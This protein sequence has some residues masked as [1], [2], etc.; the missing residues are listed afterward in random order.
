MTMIWNS[1]AQV[2]SLVG[3]PI[4]EILQARERR[5]ALDG[6]DVIYSD[7]VD[8]IVRCTYRIWDE[9]NVGLIRTHYSQ[10]CPVISLSGKLVGAEAMLEGTVSALAACPDRS[11]VAE[12]VIWC[13]EEPG[14]FFSSHRIMSTSSHLGPDAVLG[15]PIKSGRAPIPVIADCVCRNNRII[16][17]WL[18][19]DYAQFVR[20]S[21]L[22]PR[23]V[24]E[25][26]ARS[27]LEGDQE[28]HRWLQD[29]LERVLGCGTQEPPVDHP[30]HNAARA[31]RLAY[32]Q[33]QYG[34]AANQAAA[35]IEL[36]WPSARHLVGR[37]A[38]IGCLMQL[39]A[40][41]SEHQ[42]S[43]DHWA[44]RPLP[45]GD[46]AVALRWWLIGV[47]RHGGIWGTPSGRRLAILGISHF[48]VRDGRLI[49]DFT[50]FDE[51]GVLRQAAGGFGACKI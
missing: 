27:D 11:P 38:W 18:V 2:P 23:S 19:R 17:E 5:Q 16:Q 25:R 29:E 4:A 6:F 47:H 42:F 3:R 44:A 10:D 22:S 49:E 48:R 1:D 30:A 51:I 50:V 32:A 14:L 45:D 26:L 15:I 12:D 7:F 41:L 36:R 21:G 28:R 8:Y 13:Q 43:L 39:R 9:K 34:S 37:G 35:A 24:A 33:E 46:V 31:L 20:Q 40:P